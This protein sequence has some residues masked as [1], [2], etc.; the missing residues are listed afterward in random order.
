MSPTGLETVPQARP[1]RGST[2]REMI[3]EI[4][5]SRELLGQM[6]LRDV[7]LRVRELAKRDYAR[8][9]DRPSVDYVL[10]FLPNEKVSTFIHEHDGAW[11]ETVYP[12]Y[13]KPAFIYK[14]LPRGVRPAW[15][16]RWFGYGHLVAQ[17]EQGNRTLPM[18]SLVSVTSRKDCG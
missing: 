13:C 7:R 10:L 5:V 4:A 1:T 17:P 18:M 8:Q 9:G 16:H 14:V 11:W 6:V 3:C 15:R 2:W 12:G